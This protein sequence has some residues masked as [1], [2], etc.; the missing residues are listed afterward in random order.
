MR[1]NLTIL[2]AALLLAATATRAQDFAGGA[3]TQADPWLVSTPQQL[4]S[5]RNW[6]GAAHKDK[7]FKLVNDIHLSSYCAEIWDDD[8][9]EPVGTRTANFF[10]HL[11]G[12]GYQVTGLWM[13]RSS[14]DYAGLFGVT[15]NG[16]TIDRLGIVIDNERGGVKGRLFVGGLTGDSG[17]SITNCHVAGDVTGTGISEDDNLY[18]GGLT[19]RNSGSIADSDATGDVRGTGNSEYTFVG[20]L[21]GY[22][23][24]SITNC[25]AT[26]DVTETADRSYRNYIGGLAGYSLGSIAGSHAT[27][28][29]TGS[30]AEDANIVGGLLGYNSAGSVAGCYATGNVTG[31]GTSTTRNNLVGGLAGENSGSGGNIINSY[32]TGDLTGSGNSAN[33]GGL[34]GHTNGSLA[35][36]YAAC[37]I[38]CDVTGRSS[39]G[40][41]TGSGYGSMQNCYFLQVAGGPDG[42]ASGSYS[43]NVT[44]LSVTRMKMQSSFAGFDFDRVWEIDEGLTYPYLR[45]AGVQEPD[46]PPSLTVFPATLDF[47]ATGET[48]TVSVTSGVTWTV[49]PD[50]ASW[51]TVSPLSGN[52]NGTITVAAAA[53]TGAARTARVVVG[54][55][56]ITDTVYITQAEDETSSATLAI[57]P[58]T[59][60]FREG[61]L[62]VDTP[63]AERIEV[64]SL[65]GVRVYQ[66]EKDAGAATFRLP[67]LPQGIRIVRGSSGWIRK[68]I[69]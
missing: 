10:G 29:V 2:I 12:D 23:N 3:G 63:V 15:G 55:G 48:Q 1:K 65:Q 37:D 18:V 47:V 21:T 52:D 38:T 19:G 30:G 68:R 66:A 69:N 16:C 7:Y 62:F 20:G 51:L 60:C 8:G 45:D 31:I 56:G 39:A 57:F 61:N 49:E 17:G 32:A 42:V 67:R 64:Y 4:S 25:H 22:S 34:T 41:F 58:E 26:G 50:Y 36:C 5:L 46:V 27:G 43:G 40:S 14:A 9:W 33:V 11:D 35:N 24:G 28:N 54:G 59:V 44:G 53:N 13:N 6:Q